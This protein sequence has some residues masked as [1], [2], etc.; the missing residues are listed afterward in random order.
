MVKKPKFYTTDEILKRGAD[1]NVLLGLRSNGKTT[2]VLIEYVRRYFESACKR[3]CC[4]IRRWDSDF[5]QGKANK[6]FDVLITEGYIERLSG[7]EYNSV[8]YRS[9]AWFMAYNDPQTGERITEMTEPFCYAISINNEEHYKSVPY[10]GVYNILFDEFVSRNGYITDEF[11]SYMNILSTIIRQKSDVTIFMCGNTISK[12]C[13]YFA[14]MGLTH[15][16]QMHPGDI[17]VYEYGAS[18]LRVAVEYTDAP[19][20]KQ[21]SAKYFAFDNPKL[22]M[23]T[24]GQWELEIYPHLPM[25]Y[26]PCDVVYTFYIDFDGELMQGNVISAGD[27]TFIFYHRKTT[28]I[29]EDNTRLVY[30]T[31]V[32]YRRNYRVNILQPYGKA[33]KMIKYLHDIRKV[34]Y[35]DNEIGDIIHNYILWCRQH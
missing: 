21:P 10:P 19:N 17:D 1:Y 15:I 31:A 22:N 8:Y 26:R 23:I 34:F 32:D 6:M 27:N 24:N 13:P 16:K 5:K 35:Q 12:F 18:G 14:E 20:K 29:A 9:G 28:P 2:A 4:I 7:G 25:K 3:Q 33:D 30:Q 11:V